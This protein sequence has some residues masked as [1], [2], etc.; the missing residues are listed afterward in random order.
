MGGTPDWGTKH[1]DIRT[2]TIR[3]GRSTPDCALQGH[4]GVATMGLGSKSST[5]PNNL[6]WGG[7]PMAT[8]STIFTIS[9]MS[10]TFYYFDPILPGETHKTP[11]A[12]E[13]VLLTAFTIQAT[14]C[15]IPEVHLSKSQSR[16]G[17]R[18]ANLILPV[19]VLVIGK[20]P[21]DRC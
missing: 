15:R 12:L 17:A 8:I 1:R 5:L 13:H 2:R 21:G 9:T 11:L 20:K 6:S 18:Y 4:R 16:L 7:L 10:S 19:L 14:I 3:T